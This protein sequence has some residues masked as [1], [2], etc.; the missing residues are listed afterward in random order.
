MKNSLALKITISV[1]ICLTI[2][3][4]SGFATS[5]SINSWY[6]GINKPI[7][8]P[9]GWIFGPVWTVLYT[10]MGVSAGVIWNQGTDQ[11]RVK[12]ALSVFGIHLL[13]NG[14]WSLIFFGLQQPMWAFFEIIILFISIL[15][16][17][18]LFYRIKPIA[19]WIQVP[20]I[21]WVS[22]ASVLNGAIA[23]LN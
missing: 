7:F 4:L 19:G 18:N 20:Y 10:L 13:L 12:T 21:L 2:G 8:N 5:G 15:Y 22:F 1:I 9:P 17:T 14:A 11:K 23:W 6:V 16:F 3:G